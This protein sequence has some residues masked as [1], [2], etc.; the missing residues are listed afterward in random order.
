MNTQDAKQHLNHDELLMAMVDKGSLTAENRDHLAVCP[1]CSEDLKRL[2]QRFADIGRTA[3]KLA[4][5]PTK[6]FRLPAGQPQSTT[7]FFRPVWVMG[8]SAAMLLAIVVWRPDWIGNGP[9]A[10][11]PQATAAAD[12]QLMKEID[13]LVDDA[14][15]TAYQQLAYLD[16]PFS[17]DDTGIGEDLLDWVVPSLDDTDGEES[18]L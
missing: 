13:A 4:P 6:P 10:P 5:A 14:L 12:R 3:K 15:P 7:R 18:L 11:T 17:A 8:F 2:G 9:T 16:D 1:T